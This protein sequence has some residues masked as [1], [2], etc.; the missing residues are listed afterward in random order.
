MSLQDDIF[1]IQ[2]E[3][4]DSDYAKR[5]FRRITDRIADYERELLEARKFRQSVKDGVAAI[6]RLA[7]EEG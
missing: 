6:V 3:I 1:D 7:M 4:K 2:D 5:A